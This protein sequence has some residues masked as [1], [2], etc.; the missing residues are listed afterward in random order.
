[1]KHVLPGPLIS[2]VWVI[3]TRVNGVGNPHV[4]IGC[5]TRRSAPGANWM[6]WKEVAAR[7]AE[8]G[9]ASPQ[10]PSASPSLRGSEPATKQ[11]RSRSIQIA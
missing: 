1:M 6:R 8:D 3:A 11:P 2:A 4:L 7:A 10:Y 9:V 5:G